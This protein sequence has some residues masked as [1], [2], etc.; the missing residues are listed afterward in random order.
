MLSILLYRHLI[1]LQYHLASSANLYTKPSKFV[2]LIEPDQTQTQAM[3]SRLQNLIKPK[4]LQLGLTR[5]QTWT[6]RATR[7]ALNL[8]V[9]PGLTWQF[10]TSHDCDQYCTI[11]ISRIGLF[12]PYWW[13]W[14]FKKIQQKNFKETGSIWVCI[15]FFLL[16]HQNSPAPISGAQFHINLHLI[17]KTMSHFYNK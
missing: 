12:S 16:K 10:A 1:F 11:I 4:Q 17:K 5:H 3:R 9:E 6:Q 2:A 15:R 13:L 7:P 14:L 8:Q